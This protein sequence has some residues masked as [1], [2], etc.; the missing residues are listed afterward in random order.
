VTNAAELKEDIIDVLTAKLVPMVAGSPGIGKSD[1][2]QAI[3]K[4][5]N[6]FVIDMRLSQ[7]DP[8]DMLGFPTHNGERMG[9][10][11]PEHFPLSTDKIPTYVVTDAQG[12]KKTMPYAGW[13]LFMDEFPT[14][15]MAVQAAAY[16][17]V[18]ERKVGKHDLH[19]KCAIVC[20]GNKESDGAIV[21]RMSTAMQSR[22]IHLE[23]DVNP[24]LWLEWAT[25]NGLDHRVCSY[26]E[27]RPDHL[28]LF[29]PDHDDKT[30][31]C[32][33]TWE[34]ASKLIKD[35]E[36]GPRTLNLLVGTLS[37]GVATEF[38]SY[39]RYCSDIPTMAQILARPDDI[40]L[41]EDPAMLYATSHMVAAYLEEKNSDRLMRYIQRLPLEFG[42]TA[43]RAA[44]KRNKEL[45]TLSHVRDWAHKVAEEIF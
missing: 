7:C 6:L 37:A 2:I 25:E 31:A 17:M 41:P 27:G 12:V 26:I 11:P 43:V 32:P 45:L 8:T 4:Q 24:K 42:T 1:I 15:P 29:K 28:H 36:V 20:A 9:Y 22:L 40:E 44:L 3:A 18:L 33:R 14:A 39:L 10:A 16:K 21:N 13:M 19:T 38:H 30:F 5:F 23:L 35:K 34:F